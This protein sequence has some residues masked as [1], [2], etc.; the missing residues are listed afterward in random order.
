MALQARVKAA[1]RTK[2]KRLN[3]LMAANLGNEWNVDLQHDPLYTLTGEISR[4][5]ISMLST[6][7]LEKRIKIEEKKLAD[8]FTK[9]FNRFMTGQVVMEQQIT[10]EQAG[11]FKSLPKKHKKGVLRKLI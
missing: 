1:R 10:V 2:N 11:A 5:N 9:E 6:R 3:D 4:M 8:T 7:E